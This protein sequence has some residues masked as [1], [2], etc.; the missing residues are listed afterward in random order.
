M[1]KKTYFSWQ[2]LTR[3]LTDP[4][5]L[6][7]TGNLWQRNITIDCLT[8]FKIAT[9]F[10]VYSLSISC[11]NLRKV[12]GVHKSMYVG[13][14]KDVCFIIIVNEQKYNLLQG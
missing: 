12:A 9:I 11:K 7:G 1:C 6:S 4:S 14:R 5:T 10:F 13:L 3:V 2:L 8:I